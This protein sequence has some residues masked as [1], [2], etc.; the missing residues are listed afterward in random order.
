MTSR[1]KSRQTTK[2][3]LSRR[4]HDNNFKWKKRETRGK[5]KYKVAS[6]LHIGGCNTNIYIYKK[7]TIF[8]TPTF[9]RNVVATVGQECSK[10]NEPDDNNK[11]HD[12]THTKLKLAR[13]PNT[14]QMLI[15]PLRITYREKKK[16][17]THIQKR[18]GRFRAGVWRV[19]IPNHSH[20]GIEVKNIYI[21]INLAA[22]KN[23]QSH[24]RSADISMRSIHP[25]LP[26]GQAGYNN[27][28]LIHGLRNK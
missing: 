17:R 15:M 4:E 26:A 8:T 2:P 7:A 27:H 16:T 22:Q 1:Q 10:I 24:W 28:P 13:A 23:C 11:H 12:K 9:V 3:V 5:N 6:L 19:P 21:I 14:R 20:N 18:E 25:R